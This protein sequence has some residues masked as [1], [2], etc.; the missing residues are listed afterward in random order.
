M[1]I[2]AVALAPYRS[3]GG[4]LLHSV[5][6]VCVWQ[7]LQP[8][9]Q[10]LRHCCSASCIA[11]LVGET[12]TCHGR[13]ASASFGIHRVGLVESV[14]PAPAVYAVPVAMV[15]YAA[16][17]LA[18]VVTPPPLLPWVLRKCMWRSALLSAY[19]VRGGRTPR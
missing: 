14:A 15:Q 4:G 5:P 13:V 16:Q 8:C 2:V 6:A 7:Q 12:S 3:A 1:V 19:G 10:C 18:V 9:A 17:M 11:Y